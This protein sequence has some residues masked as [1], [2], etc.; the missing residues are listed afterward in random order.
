MI[1]L[2]RSAML[3]SID[4]QYT[5]E[6]ATAGLVAFENWEAASATATL[7]KSFTEFEPYRPGE[8]Y[9]RELPILLDTLEPFLPECSH[10]LVDGY[11]DLD[12]QNRLGLGRHLYERLQRAVVVIGVAKSR[13]RD[14]QHAVEIIRGQSQRP[15]FITSAGIDYRDAAGHVKQMH[16]LARIPTL[17]KLADSL[18]RGHR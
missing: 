12:S 8:F 7:T 5:D 16:G 18:A 9:L 11:V 17:L 1:R 15:L 10:I 6:L 14:S 2:A 4:V 3:I 13:F